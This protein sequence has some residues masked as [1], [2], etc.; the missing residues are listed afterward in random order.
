MFVRQ[1]RFRRNPKTTFFNDKESLTMGDKSERLVYP[2]LERDCNPTVA[3]PPTNIFDMQSEDSFVADN[4][5]CVKVTPSQKRLLQLLKGPEAADFADALKKVHY[6]G[7]YSVPIDEYCPS[8]SRYTHLLLDAIQDM[9]DRYAISKL[10][11]S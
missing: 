7:T 11:N 2:F 6:N 5:V 9:A 4:A 3:T 10:Q 1:S 8:S